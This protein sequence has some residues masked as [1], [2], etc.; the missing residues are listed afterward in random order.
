MA[1]H[2]VFA[3]SAAAALFLLVSALLAIARPGQRFWPPTPGDRIAYRRFWWPFRLLVGGVVLLA[4]LDY[5]AAWEPGALLTT[6]GA[7]LLFVG[8]GFGFYLSGFLGWNDAHGDPTHLTTTGWYAWS[9][10][11]IYVATIIGMIGLGV[12]VGSW[13]ESVLL[14]L[15]AALYVVAPFLEEPWLER[16][17]GDQ[18]VAYQRSVP[19]FV[20]VRWR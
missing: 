6:I 20:G 17:F 9:R 2:T 12:L 1:T 18:Y 14:L 15:W 11:P 13:L 7:G 8:F 5:R 10:N 3:I 4:F 19:R 16:E